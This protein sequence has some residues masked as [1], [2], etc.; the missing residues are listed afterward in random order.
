[1]AE[2][3]FKRVM[4]AF[5]AIC[6]GA[7]GVSSPTDAAPVGTTAKY[8]T[9]LAQAKRADPAT[10]FTALR[11]AYA[12]T[13]QYDPYDVDINAAKAVLRHA[14]GSGRCASALQAA[15][16]VLKRNYVDIESHAASALCLQKRGNAKARLHDFIAR[17]L[18]RSILAS[19]D[20]KAPK[21]AYVAITRDE[22]YALLS[23]QGLRS[24][25]RSLVSLDG[26]AFD[27]AEVVDSAG[28]ASIVYFSVD[29]IV[30]RATVWPPDRRKAED[31]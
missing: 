19:G 14:A 31:M 11:F 22:E 24:T 16:E 25:R 29:R 27:R 15:A 5:V 26:H 10:D 17:G 21:T 2:R 1:V 30:T 7:L 6:A 4:V 8:E 12:D 13:A 3:F 28:A 9:L 23:T 20:G 18:V